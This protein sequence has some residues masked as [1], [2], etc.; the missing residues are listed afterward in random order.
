MAWLIGSLLNKF[1]LGS[2]VQVEMIVLLTFADFR[3]ILTR[4]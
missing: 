1:D 2:S 3:V 4:T